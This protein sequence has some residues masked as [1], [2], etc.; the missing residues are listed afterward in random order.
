MLGTLGRPLTAV[1]LDEHRAQRLGRMLPGVRVGHADAL[2]HPLDAAVIVGNIPFHLTTPILR[3]LLTAPGW[4]DAVLLTQW[5]VARK[6]AG[7]GG[8]TMMTAQSGPWFEFAL[9]G[10]VPARA[11]TLVP[12]TKRTGY[13]RFVRATVRSGVGPGALPRD[14][15]PDQWAA[16]WRQCIRQRQ[17]LEAPVRIK[18]TG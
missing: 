17:R 5:E 18:R 6:R 14:L 9:H 16:L 1:E 8:G 11:R 7:V 10:R 2:K 4:L 15:S 12:Y 3:R 13:E